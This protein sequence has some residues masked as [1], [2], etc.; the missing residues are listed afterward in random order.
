MQQSSLPF[1]L[2]A[3]A[4][5]GK[6]STADMAGI[7]AVFQQMAGKIVDFPWDASTG[8]ACCRLAILCMSGSLAQCIMGSA[9][10]AATPLPRPSFKFGVPRQGRTSSTPPQR[11]CALRSP[12]WR[13]RS[14][15]TW[16]TCWRWPQETWASSQRSCRCAACTRHADD[17]LATSSSHPSQ[18]Y[19]N[20][21]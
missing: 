2:Q 5:K 13:S 1:L 21:A 3:K 15:P 9:H 4:G 16:P 10:M 18:Q 8:L 14:A 20:L 19:S 17:V 7:P 11:A 12:G 6:A